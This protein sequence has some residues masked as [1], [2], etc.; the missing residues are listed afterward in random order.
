MADKFRVTWSRTEY[1]TSVESGK[2]N[3]TFLSATVILATTGITK[4]NKP[5]PNH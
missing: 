2:M 5:V 4:A 1:L 3:N